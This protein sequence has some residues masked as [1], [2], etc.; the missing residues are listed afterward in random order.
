MPT[1]HELKQ[2]EI[3]ETPLFL[4]ECRL[5][6]GD[7]ERWSTHQVSVGGEVFSARVAGHNAF[8]LRAA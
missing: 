2:L 5:R 3:T 6:N 1:V 8:D 4:F 7:V